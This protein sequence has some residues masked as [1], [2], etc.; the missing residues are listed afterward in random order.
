MVKE[1]YISNPCITRECAGY[2]LYS[3][4]QKRVILGKGREELYCSEE[5]FDTAR[6]ELYCLEELCLTQRRSNYTVQKSYF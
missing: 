5:L 1:G 6:K 4:A 2:N 3:N